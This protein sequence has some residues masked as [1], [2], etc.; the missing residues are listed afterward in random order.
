M[1]VAMVTNGK[2]RK[3][4]SDQLDRLDA[5][6]DRQ[7]SILD[8]LSDALG[9]AVNDATRIGVADGVRAAVV[10]LLTNAELRSALHK[11]TA[12]PASEKLTFWQKVKART[13]RAVNRVKEVTATVRQK[14]A[15]KIAGV[16]SAASTAATP[17]WVAWRMRKVALV[18][19]GIGLVVAAIC[20]TG[21][22]SL[23]AGV[24]GVLAA[25]TAVAV[26]AGIWVRK[27]IRRLIVV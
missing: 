1:N 10:E 24:S 15:E 11:A 18:G 12:P 13:Q 16:K 3:Q 23:A 26:Q 22:H 17:A 21:S 19:L 14:I 25:T 20:Y 5:Q 27:T 2:P 7:D 8:G 9:E 4:L 6:M